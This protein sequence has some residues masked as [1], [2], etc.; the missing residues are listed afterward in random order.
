MDSSWICEA[1]DS[2]SAIIVDTCSLVVNSALHDQ[3]NPTWA[4]LQW[5]A[6]AAILD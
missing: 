2:S 3:H 6:K 4:S 5:D 1:Q